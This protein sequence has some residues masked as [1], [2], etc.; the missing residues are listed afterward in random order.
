MAAIAHPH[1][2]YHLDPDDATKIAAVHRTVFCEEYDFTSEFVWE[3]ERDV[4]FVA[5][6]GWP[7]AGGVWLTEQDGRVCG[8]LALTFEGQGED[9]LFTGQVRWFA[10]EMELRGSGLGRQL[11]E[12]LLETAEDQGMEKL[13]LYTCSELKAAAHLY[14]SYG[15]K[16][17]AETERHGWRRDGGA[18][19]YQKY[20]A[21]L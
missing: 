10:L 2:R 11:F 15:F 12:D 20:V 1:L 8:S 21:H 18:V 9:G 16:L 6:C 13:E 14:R 3:V 5:A 17:K 4:R 7:E 19:L